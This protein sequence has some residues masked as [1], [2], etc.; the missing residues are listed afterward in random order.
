MSDYKL[1]FFFEGEIGDYLLIGI[2]GTDE[3]RFNSLKTYHLIRNYCFVD[4]KFKAKIPQD[5]DKLRMGYPRLG[6]KQVISWYIENPT[7]EYLEKQ[8]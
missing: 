3:F 6:P 4:K 7:R 8:M 5:S 2:F 1:V